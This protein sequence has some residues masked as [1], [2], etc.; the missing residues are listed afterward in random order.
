MASTN[1]NPRL[2]VEHTEIEEHWELEI[3]LQRCHCRYAIVRNYATV[4]PFPRYV[5]R[6]PVSPEFPYYL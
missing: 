3:S 1:T 4:L 5:P 6:N 2:A